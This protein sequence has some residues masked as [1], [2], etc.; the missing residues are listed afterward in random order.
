MP[1]AF[2]VWDGFSRERGNKRGL[3]VWYS[4]YVEPDVVPSAV[5]PMIRTALV[6]F[7]IE[8]IVIAW[9]RWRYGPRTGE[10]RGGAGQPAATSA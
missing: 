7:A 4:L 5:G 9:A 6:I 3:T 10:E 2:S 1:I 8:L